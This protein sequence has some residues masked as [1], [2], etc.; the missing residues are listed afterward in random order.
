MI[1]YNSILTNFSIIRANEVND[2]SIIFDSKCSF[3]SHVV[4][5]TYQTLAKLGFKLNALE[6]NSMM[7]IL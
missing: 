7:A 3:N 4:N 6:K 2:L 1:L 5:I